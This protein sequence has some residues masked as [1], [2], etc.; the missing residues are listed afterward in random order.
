MNV[1]LQNLKT[2]DH[3]NG[4]GQRHGLIAAAGTIWEASWQAHLQLRVKEQTMYW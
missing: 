4:S 1:A 2:S 3:I